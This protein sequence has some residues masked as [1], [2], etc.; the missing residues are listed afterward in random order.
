VTDS[1]KGGTSHLTWTLRISERR[2]HDVLV[3]ELAG[4]ISAA[5]AEPFAERIRTAIAGG[6]RRL[7]LDMASVDYL[8]S[9]GI[10]LLESASARLDT[11]RGRL[12]LC[13]VA[14]PVRIVLQLA[15]ALDRLAVDMTLAEAVARAQGS[16]KP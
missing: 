3:L 16:P 15:G 14:D 12:V 9:R 2:V 10:Q 6:A 13:A 11:L 7:V 1:K 8:S 5:D 4:R